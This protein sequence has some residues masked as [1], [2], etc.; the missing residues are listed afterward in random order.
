MA[1]KHTLRESSKAIQ[2]L[3]KTKSETEMDLLNIEAAIDIDEQT[4]RLKMTIQK[5]IKVAT[6]QTEF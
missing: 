1:F 5:W 6:L 3:Q 4:A 2:M